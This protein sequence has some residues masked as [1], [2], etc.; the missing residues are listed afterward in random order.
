MVNGK[1][2]IAILPAYN[3]ERTLGQTVGAIPRDIVDDIILVDDA[4]S[5]KT[6]EAAR[7]LGIKTF[8]HRKNVGYGGN[9]KTCY[10]EAIAAGAD[11][12][13]MV[14][15]DFQYD[16]RFIPQLVVPIAEGKVD[17]VFGSRMLVPKNALKGGMPRW[18]FFANIFLTRIE[19]FILGYH[20]S[21]Y[22]SGFRAYSKRVLSAL[23]IELNSNGFVFDTEIIAQM[24]V[25]SFKILE[26]PITTRYFPGAS[27]IGLIRSSEY[28]LRI[29]TV[30]IRYLLH[31]WGILRLQKFLPISGDENLVC[32]NCAAQRGLLIIKGTVNL[33]DML[34]KTNYSL[35]EAENG[36]FGDIYKCAR[37]RMFFVDRRG[38]SDALVNHYEN[39]P[40]DSNYIKGE[41]FR[42]RTFRRIL[43]RLKK[44][45]G[46]LRNGTI[47]DIG[48]G[49]G[50]FLAEAARA[51]YD[52]YG[53]EPSITAVH[54]AHTELNLT[55]VLCGSAD[56]ID[57]LFQD[58]KFDI[59][60]AFDVLEHIVRPREFL[61]KL[62]KHLKP[63][64]IIILT[65]PMIDS[66]GATF[67]GRHWH[68]LL[69]SH[70]NYFTNSSL[71]EF[72]FSLGYKCEYQRWYLR[73]FPVSYLLKRILKK[74]RMRYPP[75]L[76]FAIPTI[77]FD[78]LEIY[79]KRHQ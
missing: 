31:R 23:P 7:R 28:G 9:Q 36:L 74:P 60:T 27:M 76:D 38:I 24:K 39:Q 50:F 22:H 15:P 55:N 73:F 59:I 70:L 4:S 64:G 6:V 44:I 65:I 14:H 79:L 75:F 18:K 5:D 11:I 58:K 62:S 32:P 33:K 63:H 46:D 16:P 41:A 40:L 1:K 12:V 43:G 51:G 26:I 25:A 37:C 2:I 21:E 17:A 48:C 45:R 19:N 69:P 35:T 54:Y 56:Q 10:K 52:V 47:L 20:L 67:F 53:V 68:A 77:L 66:P 61:E 34:Q 29:L 13:V 71:K 49:V 42:E 8:V 78:E 72:Y 30:M 3:A 57:E